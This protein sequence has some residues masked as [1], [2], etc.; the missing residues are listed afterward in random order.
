MS[1]AGAFSSGGGGGGGVTT[2][3]GDTGSA[4]GSTI[5]LLGTPNGGASV[6][7]SASGSTIN[8][9]V[10][11][12]NGNTFVGNLAGNGTLS[13]ASNT[14]FGNL[15]L[16]TLTTGT[17]N[18]AVGISSLQTISTD[19]SNVAIGDG[20]LSSLQGSN[21]KNTA[22]GSGCLPSLLT[23]ASNTCVGYI[24]GFHYSGAETNNILIGA[25]V[26]GTSGESTTTRIGNQATQTACFIAGIT[27]VTVANSAAVLIDTTSGQLGT[28]AS[29]ARYK[30]NIKDL[31]D[32]SSPIYNLRPVTFN[33]KKDASKIKQCGLIAEEVLQ[34]M[35]ELVVFKG[36]EP[37]TVKY[38]DLPILLLAEIQKLKVQI[39]LLK[40]RLA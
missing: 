32:E 17:A 2:I 31:Q 20:V 28:V 22:M 26:L 38:H 29:S 37:E 8:L 7:F 18:T 5:S 19:N 3:A 4:T 25:S 6:S 1:N 14:G 15:S 39:E 24:A 21:G 35:P 12:F 34:F 23:G 9:N 40:K 11:D 33:Y 36:G 16:S 10:S 13:G 27:G 30:E